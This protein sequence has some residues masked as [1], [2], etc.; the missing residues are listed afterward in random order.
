MQKGTK[1][2]LAGLLIAGLALGVFTLAPV[3]A[4][5]SQNTGHLGVHAWRQVIKQRA[6]RRYVR[7]CNPGS[8]LAWAY[9][10]GGGLND[11][12]FR[13]EGI[14]PQYNCAGAKITGMRVSAGSYQLRIPGIKDSTGG[15]NK[16]V[17]T[18]TSTNHVHRLLSHDVHG[19]DDYLE[20]ESQDHQ[21][22]AANTDFV[23]VVYRRP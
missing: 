5:F 10:E 1:R 15:G 2:S 20:V 21:G 8:A 9:I 3:S 11:L 17:A 16:L 19:V 6:D 14:G 7:K 13:R 23:I 18:L 4:H 22:I 12:N